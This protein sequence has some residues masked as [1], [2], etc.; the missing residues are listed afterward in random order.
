MLESVQAR[1]SFSLSSAVV[2]R[3]LS[4]FFVLKSWTETHVYNERKYLYLGILL[5]WSLENEIQ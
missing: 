1:T 3:L 5:L 4:F 2:L